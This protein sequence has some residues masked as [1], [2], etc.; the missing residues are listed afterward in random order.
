MFQLLLCITPLTRTLLGWPLQSPEI[1]DLLCGL[2][3]LS[4]GLCFQG[5]LST[6]ET[7]SLAGPPEVPKRQGTRPCQ[8]PQEESKSRIQNHSLLQFHLSPKTKLGHRREP[9]NETPFS[10][11][12]RRCGVATTWEN[13]SSPGSCQLPGLKP[14]IFWVL[15]L[16][17][18]NELQLLGM[19]VCVGRDLL[20]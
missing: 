16:G 4:T 2:P 7:D 3:Y 1:G 5:A 18:Q 9:I 15:L 6:S 10:G 14:S 11:A 17:E 13:V 12:P 20:A 8:S 19:W